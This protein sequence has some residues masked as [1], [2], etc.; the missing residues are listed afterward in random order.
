VAHSP[1]EEIAVG[2]SGNESGDRSH[3][4]P[5]DRSHSRRWRPRTTPNG[6]RRVTRPA[7]N[8]P[9]KVTDRPGCHSCRCEQR[10]PSPTP[11]G[12]P[13]DVRRGERPVSPG[14]PTLPKGGRTCKRGTGAWASQ[15]SACMVPKDPTGRSLDGQRRRRTAHATGHPDIRPPSP[16]VWR[17]VTRREPEGT[18]DV[19]RDDP[20]FRRTESRLLPG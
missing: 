10:R 16:K 14:C 7:S 8:P 15:C 12:N 17:T 13:L 19:C 6:I 9:K 20:P 1:E 2:R 11:D 18:R 5:G 3:T 4:K